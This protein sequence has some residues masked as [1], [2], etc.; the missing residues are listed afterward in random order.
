MIAVVTGSNGFI[1]SH[2][3]EALLEQGFYIRCLHFT[4][5]GSTSKNRSRIEH[6]TIDYTDP[7]AIMETRALED[8]EY[9]F[10]LAGV[11]KC[12]TMEEFRS[13]NVLP[14]K[15]LLQVL[16]KGKN[17][18]KR[19]VYISSQAAAGPA[20]TFDNPITEANI[21][22]PIESYG[23]SKLE[24]ERIVQAYADKIPFT[25]IRPC[26]VYGPRDVDFL[27]VVRLI[28]NHLSIYPGYRDKYISIIYVT[29]LVNGILRAAQSSAT[30][31]KTYFLCADEPISWC[32]I[33]NT[34]ANIANK[35]VIELSIPQFIVDLVCKAGDAYSRITGKYSLM[36]SQKIALSKPN[37]WICSS[38]QAK[39][40]FGFV[41]R[42]SLKQGME[43]VYRWYKGEY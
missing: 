31:G 22:E 27:N 28:D 25:I 3:V 6:Y 33:H 36:N 41:T 39:Q 26:A 40:D 18:L 16:V 30:V 32:S 23:Q 11:T 1:G 19:I 5:H 10:H 14:T 7:H 38:E 43:M 17:Q 15:N 35:Y 4:N 9:V 20:N 24:A 21:P 12:L 2:L 29:D 37:Y 42:V 8:A 13:G 34:F